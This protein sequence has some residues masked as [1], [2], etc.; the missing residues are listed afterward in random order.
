MRTRWMKMVLAATL[1]APLA[2]QAM[3]VK[4]DLARQAQPDFRQALLTLSRQGGSEP[5][6][7]ATLAQFKSLIGRYGWPTVAAVGRDGVDAAGRLLER[8]TRDDDFQSN[9]EDAISRDID[10]DID[11]RAFAVLN[12]RIEISHHRPQQ[13]GT[14]FAVANGRVVLSPPLDSLEQA[15]Q[16]RA[17][18]GLPTVANDMKRLEGALH[19]GGKAASLIAAPELS[20]PMH[21]IEMP[22]LREELHQMAQ[23]DQAVRNSVIQSGMKRGSAEQAQMIKVDAANQTRLKAIFAAYGFPDRRMVGRQGVEDAWLLVQH[24][25]GDKPL[26]RQALTMAAPLM[27]KGDIPRDD[28][29]MLT[30]RV[31]LGEGKKQI[32]G[33]QLTGKPGHFVVRPLE[34]PVHVDARRASMG[35]A[36]LATYIAQTNVFY[37]PKASTERHAGTPQPSAPTAH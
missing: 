16:L 31:R 30:D 6:D 33:T 23:R 24:A 36:P 25:T 22:K 18:I 10:A 29:A 11:A 2:L 7:T 13:F 1:C 4:A 32:Y 3:T 19:D 27:R 20:T 28:Y 12:D 37:T 9:V 8:A 15:D 5:L 26:M 34:D 17:S 35:L 14:L 21:R